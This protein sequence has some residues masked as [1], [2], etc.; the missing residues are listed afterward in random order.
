MAQPI[1][2]GKAKSAL[3]VGIICLVFGFGLFI[4][5]CIWASYGGSDGTGI[6]SGILF[7]IPG[8]LGIVVGVKKNRVA[9]IFMLVLYILD[10]ILLAV[11]CVIALLAWLIWQLVIGWVKTSCNTVGN[12]CVCTGHTLPMSVEDCD[13]VYTVEAIFLA[14][15]VLAGLGCIMALAGSIIGCM[16]VCCASNTTTNT[17]V[18]VQ[19]QPVGMHQQPV[20]LVPVD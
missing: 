16:G 7:M 20:T 1:E 17:T 11:Q 13:W 10:I 14:V 15:V 2:A 8:I 6:W 4:C 3:I 5:G 19:Q 12:N 18:I 9:M